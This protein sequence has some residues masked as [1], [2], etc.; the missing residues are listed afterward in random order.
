[1]KVNYI[2]RDNLESIGPTPED[3]N[4]RAKGN[5]LKASVGWGEVLP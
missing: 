3:T 2:E 4:P 5:Q 1:M